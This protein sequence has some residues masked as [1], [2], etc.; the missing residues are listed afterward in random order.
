MSLEGV[1]LFCEN[2]T[3]DECDLIRE[4]LVQFDETERGLGLVALRWSAIQ[5][6]EG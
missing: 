5:A 6:C 2:R 1:A 4:T 3:T